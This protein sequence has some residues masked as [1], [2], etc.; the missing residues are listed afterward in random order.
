MSL[1]IER[2][3]LGN[4]QRWFDALA[5]RPAYQAVVMQPLS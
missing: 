5:K 1:P 3:E 2:P 4:V